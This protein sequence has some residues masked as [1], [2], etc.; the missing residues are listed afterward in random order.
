MC[1]ATRYH[2][3][4]SPF[5]LPSYGRRGNVQCML[6]PEQTVSAHEPDRSTGSATRALLVVEGQGKNRL[7]PLPLEGVRTLGRD[8]SADIHLGSRSVSRFH[9]RLCLT[10]ASASITDLESRNGTRVNGI[11]LPA[12]E[13]RQLVPGDI[14]SVGDACV[15]LQA[16]QEESPARQ[17][18]DSRVLE[19][20][21]HT[22][23][24]A[25]PSMIRLYSKIERIGP[26]DLPVL[27][28]GE[29]GTGKEA[30]AAAIH[31]YS[32]RSNKPLVTINCANLQESLAESE[33]FGHEQGSFTH[34][35]A[36]KRGLMEEANGG[37]FFLDEIAELPMAVQAKLLR[38]LQTG[39]LRRVGGIREIP[40][41]VRIVAAT[42]KNLETE[43]SAGRFRQDLFYRLSVVLLQVPPL[44]ER[45]AEIPL[46]AHRFL[47]QACQRNSIPAK[48][49]TAAAIDRLYVYSFPGNVRELRNI[50]EYVTAMVPSLEIDRD[51]IEERLATSE[52]HG[53]QGAN[54][55][56]STF[57]SDIG[58]SLRHA[59]L[60]AQYRVIQD[61]LVKTGGNKSK[62]A[63]LLHMSVRTLFSILNRHK[64]VSSDPEPK[65]S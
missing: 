59:A 49:L 40:I 36:Q 20:G 17:S 9:A 18:A 65:Y 51:D 29:T 50:I 26:F 44:R 57:E 33:L 12:R 37:T 14:I 23:L 45:P 5:L 63:E 8:P 1:I 11:R 62:A 30:C 25:D 46:L 58:K 15:V 39:M 42:H 56:K 34:A 38:V 24:L 35:V 47:A 31:H 13:V 43:V 6:P 32:G 10:P 2:E 28:R 19:V 60:A 16:S 54:S 61:A 22:V 3:A 4:R 27:L 21:H 48:S 41:S 53:K 7:L 52:E 55:H 64:R